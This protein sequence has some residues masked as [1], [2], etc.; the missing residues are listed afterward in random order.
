MKLLR[1]TKVKI[2]SKPVLLRPT[3]KRDLCL[4]S[5]QAWQKGYAEGLMKSLGWRFEIWFDYDSEKVNFY[6]RAKDFKH[7]KEVITQKIVSNKKLFELLNRKFIED[8]KALKSVRTINEG[9]IAQIFELIASAMSFYMFVVGDL[10]VKACPEAWKSR[11]LSEGVLHELDEKIEF[12]LGRLLAKS[13]INKKLAHFLTASE[14]MALSC[15]KR[16]NLSAINERRRGYIM[17]GP[18]VITGLS[19]DEFCKRRNFENTETAALTAV[20]GSLK[21]NA[22]YKGLAQGRVCVVRSRKE[23]AKFKKGNVLVAVMTTVNHISAIKKASAIVT[24]EGGIT[25]HAAIIARE[26]K[27]PCITGTKIATKIFQNGDFVEVDAV[28][29]IILFK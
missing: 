28:N 8:I 14:A 19:F 26:L 15:G 6:H 20:L 24:D 9:N 13:G 11:K 23:L 5:V 2:R 7:F 25:C 18:K 3:V 17:E 29:G 10:F 1:K 21:G 27:K 16:L 4:F 12:Y 22:A